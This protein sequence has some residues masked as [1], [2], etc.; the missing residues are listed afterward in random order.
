MGGANVSGPSMPRGSPV[1]GALIAVILV[2]VSA[3]LF[4]AIYLAVGS[5]FYAFLGIGL[6]ALVFAFGAYLSQ[7]FGLPSSIS[8]LTA[9]AYLGFGFALLLGDLLLLPPAG[10]AGPSQF[11]AIA[12]LLLLLVGAVGFIAWR[13][14]SVATTAVRATERQAWAARPAPSALDY[15]TAQA[16]PPRS[17]TPPPSPGEPGSRSP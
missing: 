4:A 2:A 1:T 7:S 17:A 11:V 5:H 6:L 9:Y 16:P 15:S 10:F 8:G 14:R 3:L 13:R 12:L